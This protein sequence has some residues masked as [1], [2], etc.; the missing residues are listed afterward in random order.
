ME[1]KQLDRALNFSIID[2]ALASIYGSLAGGIFLMGFALKI[3]NAKAEQI[4]FLAALPMFANLIQ[5]LG[6]Y[7]IE[8]TGKKKMLCYICAVA[9]RALWVLIIMLPLKIFAP[10]QDVRVWVLVVVIGISSLLGSLS[11]VGWL[12][13]MSDLVPENI[14]GTYFGKRNMIASIFGMIAILAGGKF[15]TFWETKYSEVNP[16]GFISLFIIGLAAGAIGALFLSRIP[17]AEMESKAKEAEFELS[18]FF[19]PLKDKN[20]LALILFVSAW[21]F[22]IQLAGPFY[23]VYMI[24][25]LKIDFTNISIFGAIATF[26]TLFMMKTWGPIS[27]KLGNKP[28]IIVSGLVLVVVPFIWVLALPGKYYIP[29]LLAHIL[30]GGFTAGAGLSQ[31]NILLKLS[32]KKGRSVYLASFAAITGFVGAIAPIAGSSLANIF[33]EVTFK[34]MVYDISNLHIIFLVSAVLQ[35]LTLFFILKVSE[36]AA[37]SPVAVVLQLKNDLNFQTGIAGTSDFIMLEKQRVGRILEK[38]DRATD[39]LAEKSED[40]IEKI[41]NK[42]EKIFE[43]PARKIKDFLKNDE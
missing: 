7:I 31:F 23:G 24:N 32:P 19:K 10:L 14:R 38:I 41:W 36:P 26:A 20:F 25:T 18:G 28:I 33:E 22:A 39:A 4:G 17:E 15:I 9:S 34:V 43:K 27:D 30:S 16:Y 35:L 40:Q 42:G 21:I 2:G 6:S 5:L 13:W 37:A 1:Q 8:K 29:V 11:G 3:L 12:A